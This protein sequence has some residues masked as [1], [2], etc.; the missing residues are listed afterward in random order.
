MIPGLNIWRVTQPQLRYINNLFT[1][2]PRYDIE[3]IFLPVPEDQAVIEYVEATI[4]IT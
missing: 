2:K 1:T 3:V 4:Y